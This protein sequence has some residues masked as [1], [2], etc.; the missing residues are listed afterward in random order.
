M[1][2]K[3]NGGATAGAKAGAMTGMSGSGATAGAAAGMNYDSIPFRNK[4]IDKL[5]LKELAKKQGMKMQ[6]TLT[7]KP[8]GFMDRVRNR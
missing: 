3:N 8:Q 5:M 6:R 1:A 7:K 4:A 2:Y